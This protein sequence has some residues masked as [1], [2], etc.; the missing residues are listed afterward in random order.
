MKYFLLRGK[1]KF[2]EIS[3]SVIILKYFVHASDHMINSGVTYKIKASTYA[4]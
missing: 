2:H 4:L 3:V 1:P